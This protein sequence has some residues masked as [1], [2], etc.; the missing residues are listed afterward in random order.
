MGNFIYQDNLQTERLYTRFLTIDDVDI[1]TTFFDEPECA[2]Y[3][4]NPDLL[5]AR[6]RAENWINKGLTRY[7]ENTFGLQALINKET[8]EFIGQCG[9]LKQEVD[10]VKELEVGYSL[11][12]KHWGKGYATE[13]AKFFKNYGFENKLAPS[14]IST[15]HID[16]IPS[17]Q[18]A[19][20]NGMTKEKRTKW[21][22]IDVFIFRTNQ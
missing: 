16:N 18:V 4:P 11:L 13:A 8:N 2:K 22:D 17:Q 10:G 20:R 12:R 21:N 9:L 7:K 15:I 19:L 3:F 5:N 14:I 1:W 6:T